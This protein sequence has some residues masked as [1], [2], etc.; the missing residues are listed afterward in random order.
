MKRALLKI[1]PELV[2]ERL[3]LPNGTTIES[4]TWDP[5]DRTIILDVRSD[6]FF[7]VQR[8]HVAP[9]VTYETRWRL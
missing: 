5:I 7:D 6:V 8:H 2:A 1:T 3:C 4:A 9:Y